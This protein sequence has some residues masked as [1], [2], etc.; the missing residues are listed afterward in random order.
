MATPRVNLYH[1]LSKHGAEIAEYIIIIISHI[2]TQCVM[3]LY[4]FYIRV[5]FVTVLLIISLILSQ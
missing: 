2:Y 3:I 4:P 1:P 5:E